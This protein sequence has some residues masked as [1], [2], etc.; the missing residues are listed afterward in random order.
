MSRRRRAQNAG[1]STPCA[2]AISLT[3]P[4]GSCGRAMSPYRT[5]EIMR[6][7]QERKCFYV[8]APVLA[9]VLALAVGQTVL[10]SRVDAQGRTV[11]AP[12][13]EV[14]PLWPKPP[15]THWV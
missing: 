1:K 9:L 13:F 4:Y 12:M 14:D 5:E 15:P 6:S 11:Q 7:P 2:R 8:G 3:P 10:Q